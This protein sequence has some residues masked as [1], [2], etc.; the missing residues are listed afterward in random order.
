M[1][2]HYQVGDVKFMGV[3]TGSPVC[4]PTIKVKWRSNQPLER[5]QPKDWEDWSGNLA[6]LWYNECSS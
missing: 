4:P 3:I 5:T 2:L 1:A 6:G